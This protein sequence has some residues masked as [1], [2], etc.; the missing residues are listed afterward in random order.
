MTEIWFASLEFLKKD[1]G[2]ILVILWWKIKMNEEQL[3][4]TKEVVHTGNKWCKNTV[5]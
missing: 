2:Q 3:K 4:V 1:I 5:D